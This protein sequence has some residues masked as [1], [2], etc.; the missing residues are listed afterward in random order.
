MVPATG[1][2]PPRGDLGPRSGFF[3]ADA[4]T[5]LRTGERSNLRVQ[6]PGAAGPGL[7]LEPASPVLTAPLAHKLLGTE[8]LLE[9]SQVVRLP[10]RAGSSSSAHAGGGVKFCVHPHWGRGQAPCMPTPGAGTEA[11]MGRPGVGL[12][13]GCPRSC[14]CLVCLE[15]SSPSSPTSPP[16]GRPCLSNLIG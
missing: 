15:P 10:T 11:E 7:P 1:E 14:Q 5:A 12:P 8:D 6:V 4:A 2:I 9:Q 13:S 16:S 3:S